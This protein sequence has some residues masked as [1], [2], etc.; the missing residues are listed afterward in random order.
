MKK[1]NR[2]RKARNAAFLSKRGMRITTASAL[3]LLAGAL[4]L[5]SSLYWG[6]SAQ[7]Q[8]E[9]S[10]FQLPFLYGVQDGKK[11]GAPSESLTEIEAR[12][13]ERIEVELTDFDEGVS[14]LIRLELLNVVSPEK[15]NLSGTEPRVLIYHTHTTEAYTPTNKY[16]YVECGDCRTHQ[17]DRNVV[18]LGEKLTKLLNET[19]GIVTLHDI[20]DHEPPKLSTSYDRSLV[21]IL[22]YKRQYPSLTMFIDIHR[23]DGSTDDSV[24]VNGKQV[25]R[26][27]FVVGTGKGATG[28]GYSEMPDFAANYALAK[29]MT[30]RLAQYQPNLMRDIRVKNGR[31]NQHVSNQCLLVEIGHVKNTFEQAL[32]AVDLLAEAIADVAGVEYEQEGSVQTFYQLAP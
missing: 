24:T 2:G 23:D 16:P 22:K 27:M 21:T 9:L 17:N 18:A 8:R 10:S 19:Y 28:T 14:N 30:E 31:Y 5:Q 26:M 3:L 32:N 1:G 4:V 6:G 11:G 12:D 13:E 29:K 25:A 7:A 15:I 20:T